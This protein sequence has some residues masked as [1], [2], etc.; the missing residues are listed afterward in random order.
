MTLGAIAARLALAPAYAD[1]AVLVYHCE[2]RVL[3]EAMRAAGVTA[4]AM[5]VDAPYSARTH[6]GHDSAE[7]YDASGA[8][9]DNRARQKAG[10]SPVR[11][12]LDYS[13]WDDDDVKSFVDTWSP[14]TRGWMVSLT[15]HVL[16]YAWMAAYDD[17][18][19]LDFSPL[20]C[21]EPGS[22]VRLVGDG[23][24]QWSVQACV[25]RPRTPEFAR[26]GTLPGAYVGG[27]EPKPW[28]GGKPLWLM[29]ALVRDYS[30]PGDVVV[31]PCA[32]GATTLI[33]AAMEGRSAI[34]AE[35]SADNFAKAQARIA[36]G[37]TPSMF[38]E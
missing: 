11:R 37:W 21:V 27:R 5:I 23:P 38:T 29:R 32:G 20:A 25:S 15:D 26:W 10:L 16:A 31:D 24:S 28:V 33:A 4:D 9:R 14:V 30:R 6:S 1:D 12:G 35:A 17:N 36:G 19:R 13:A 3:A 22:R 7:A 18:D 2:H 8:P 34:G